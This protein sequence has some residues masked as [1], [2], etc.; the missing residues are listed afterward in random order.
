MLLGSWCS[1]SVK[2]PSVSASR[3]PPACAPKDAPAARDAESR[4]TTAMG[5]SAGRMARKWDVR[6]V[7]QRP[8]T[9]RETVVGWRQGATS[10]ENGKPINQG[11]CC[12]AIARVFVFQAASSAQQQARGQHL[13]SPPRPP[14]PHPAPHRMAATA[15]TPAT[16]RVQLVLNV[17]EEPQEQIVQVTTGGSSRCCVGDSSSSLA[18]RLSSHTWRCRPRGGGGPAQWCALPIQ[19]QAQQ[20]GARRGGAAAATTA[21]GPSHQRS[22]QVAPEDA[23]SRAPCTAGCQHGSGSGERVR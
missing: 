11:A 12:H 13:P 19:A 6:R 10:N 3:S 22:H 18:R 16:A 5:S 17:R 9:A 15:R 20:R 21:F 23:G 8:A 14:F 2:A 4:A 7:G 1:G